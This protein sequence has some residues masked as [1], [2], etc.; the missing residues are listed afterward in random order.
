[1]HR[2]I[3]TFLIKRAGMTVKSGA[4]SG[5]VTLIQR[6]G[7]ALNL[8]LHFHM[9]YVNGVYDGKGY[10]LPVKPPT[11]AELDE[12][13]H[14]IAKRVCRYLERAG[15]L[16]RDAETEYLDLVPEED[17]AMHGI[18]GASI[19]YRLAF[20]PNARRKVL[21]LQAVPISDNR[22]KSSELVSKQAGF[23]LHS[24]VACKS[25]QRKKL[26]CP[27]GVPLCRYITRPAIAEQRLLLARN[28]NV[29]FVLKPPYADGN[30]H[31]VL[32]PMEFMGRLAALVPRPRVN[33][34]R[35]HG[36]FSSNSKLRESVVPAKPAYEAE[37]KDQS[38]NK[39]Y[40][41]TWAQRLKRVFAGRPSAIDPN[42]AR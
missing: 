2:A 11:T 16:Y 31:V 38:G 25:N 15:Y 21:T 7:S 28:G 37:I 35:F 9:L 13:T 29:I 19:T 12:I 3:S 36:V 40:S 10:F 8:N 33:L 1:M 4:Q 5:A 30:S 20:G 22:A 42:A 14:K 26:D 39:A 6:F 18:I 27:G 41:M 32:S 24:G 23:S 34:T 17:D